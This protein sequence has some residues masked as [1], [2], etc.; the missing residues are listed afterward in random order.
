MFQSAKQHLL[1]KNN[2]TCFGYTWIAFFTPE[3]QDTKMSALR[4]VRKIE[5]SDYKLRHICLSIRLS[6]RPNG[7]TRLPLRGFS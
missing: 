2:A 1:V 4:R 7:A 6:V 3:L 5:K